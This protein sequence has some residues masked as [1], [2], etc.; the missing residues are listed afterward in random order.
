MKW[1]HGLASLAIA[2]TIASSSAYAKPYDKRAVSFTRQQAEMVLPGVWRV[3]LGAPEP[4]TPLKFR[5]APRA[6]DGLAKLPPVA[7]LPIGLRQVRFER[8]ARGC[9]VEFPIEA[10]EKFY[11]LGLST[12]TFEL[13]GRKA[14]VVPSDHPEEPTNE[15]HAPEPFFV[16]SRGYGVYLD[17]ARY[18]AL[19]FGRVALSNSPKRT[20]MADIPAA[21]G[22]DVYI[23][24]GPTALVAVQRYNLFSG[25]GPLPPLW[26]LGI[27]YRGAG[28]S[29]AADILALADSFR[30]EDIPCD[31]FGVEPGWQTQTYSSSFV[32]NRT[33]FPD[34][35]GFISAMHG[36]DFRM[37]FWEHPFTHPSSPI[38][39]ALMPYS[40]SDPVWGGLVP[41]FATPQARTIFVGQ[42]DE[43]L[44]AK[45]VDSMKIDEVDNQPFKPDPWS[46]PDYSRFPS[47]LDGEQMHS[48]FGLLAQQT[49]L[50]PFRDKN[51]RTWGLVRD[52]GALAAPLPYTV[53]SDSYDHPDYIRGMA[54]IGFGG[55][56]WTPEVRDAKSVEDLIRRIQTVIFSPYAMINCWYMKMPPWKQINAD[57]SNAGQA[58]PEA[59]HTTALA[60]DL[61]RL[62][63]SLVP[64]LYS[65]FN[66]YHRTGLPVVRA[67]VLDYPG[68]AALTAI[69]DQFM[70]GPSLMVAPMVEGQAKRSVYFPAGDWFDFFT[71][72]SIH[73]G[74]RID[75]SK[76]L[77][78]LPLYV[79]A[80]S[81]LP[82]AEPV[83]H[84]GRETVFKLRIRVYGAHPT[85]FNLYEDDGE[86]F[87]YLHG[88][89]DR[90]ELSWS[91]DGG[92]ARRTGNTSLKRYEIDRWNVLGK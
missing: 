43:S 13:S 68:D 42:Q 47:G 90:L 1:T 71:G 57:K 59:A 8:S 56:L 49:L 41:D 51:R 52:S 61:F 20:V 54:K 91:T 34:P 79:K 32:W 65:A 48:L 46:F 77:D 11:G 73:G 19:T 29:S 67:L 18:A 66:E 83:A 21:Q 53:Y 15:S 12:K 88:A 35:G 14:W 70:F 63:M 40:G 36:K 44:F 6:T 84:I 45:G 28:N 33:R 50:K 27:A 37:S 87:D 4:F 16:S 82:L 55:H 39:R 72:E 80:N 38:Y 23:F 69:D 25:G 2:S 89:Q 17:T 31:I 75:I 24:G 3:R 92:Q 60:R 7:E 10:S 78:Q 74:R 62:R 5:S 86:T 64:Y 30:R 76:P 22:I 26:G 85:A 81:L 9:T 58:M